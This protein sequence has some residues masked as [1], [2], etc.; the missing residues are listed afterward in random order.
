MIKSDIQTQTPAVILGLS[1]TAL[2]VIRS[3]G[4]KGIKV[5]A[6]DYE[7]RQIASCSKYC[8]A[9]LCPDPQK[10]GDDLLKFL[11]SLQSKL[12][13]Q[14]V[15]I[16]TSDE[17]VFF[18][19]R[20]RKELSTG[21]RFRLPSSELIEALNDKREFYRIAVK[22]K[23]PT[24]KTFV[25]KCIEDLSGIS[26]TLEYP[27]VIKPAFG[28]LFKDFHF[29]AVLIKNGHDLLE[30]C[31][32]IEKHIDKVL[33]QELISGSDSAQYSVAVYFNRNSEL[34]ASFTS[35]KIRQNPPR[36][37][38]GTYVASCSEPEIENQAVTFL[39]KLN[40]Q[41]IAEVEFK[42]DSKDGIF[43]MLEVN[44]RFWTQNSLASRCGVDIPHIAYLD[45]L[46]GVV[47]SP[48]QHKEIINWINFYEDVQACFGSSGYFNM[49]DVTLGDWL[50]S[51]IYKKEHA[52]FSLGDI[53][54]FVY[55]S[56]AF[57]SKLIMRMAGRWVKKNGRIPKSYDI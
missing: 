18:V 33:I 53:G 48:T 45:I 32:N 4:Q 52:I 42:R 56:K 9:L 1:L 12:H 14:V 19:S 13:E 22:N 49:G 55:S 7:K 24:P 15:L 40:Y 3:L 5:I 43:K 26:R 31:R 35:R 34:L 57:L 21:Y 27:C 2:G 10:R 54:P 50:I 36:F 11:I 51:L 46:E 38:T 29:K 47:G 8:K 44:T 41:G 23:I 37:G 6:L 25:P 16:S 17:F 20:H 30:I 28:Y 39:K